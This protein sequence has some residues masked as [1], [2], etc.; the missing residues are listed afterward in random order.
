MHT[1]SLDYGILYITK[2]GNTTHTNERRLVIM[3]TNLSINEMW[4]K[5]LVLGVSKQTLQVVTD[6]NG[7]NEQSMKDIL[8]SVTGYNDFDQ[9]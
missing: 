6:I 9:L 2:Q 5:L 3:K 7:Y 8:Y 1:Y 4:D